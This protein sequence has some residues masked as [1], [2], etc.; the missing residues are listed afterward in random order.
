MGQR[1]PKEQD[2]YR[3]GTNPMEITSMPC[4]AQPRQQCIVHRCILIHSVRV[5]VM[6]RDFVLIRLTV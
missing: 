3:L 6:V 4:A 5:Y 2:G 1:V